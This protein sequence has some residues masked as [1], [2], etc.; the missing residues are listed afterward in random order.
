MKKIAFVL[1]LLVVSAAIAADYTPVTREAAGGQNV[2]GQIKV[3]ATTL[4]VTNGQPITLA[5]YPVILMSAAA[6]ASEVATTTFVNV[7]SSYVGS[8][9]TLI[10]VGASNAVLVTD[11]AP[12][13][14]A[15]T[16]IGPTDSITVFVKATNEIIQVGT[17][18]N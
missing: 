9:I 8:T 13:Y 18:N 6:Q 11:S 3:T 2:N 12:M 17:S 1:S 4:T 7:S 15:A 10:N 16:S 5:A 14:G